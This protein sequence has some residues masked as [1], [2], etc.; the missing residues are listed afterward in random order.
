MKITTNWQICE[1][2]LT[3]VQGR[4]DLKQC[5]LQMKKAKITH[6]VQKHMYFIYKSPG[7]LLARVR[8]ILLQVPIPFWK[9]SLIFLIKEP[10]GL[11]IL[12]TS[13]PNAVADIASR[14]KPPYNLYKIHGSLHGSLWIA[15]F[16]SL[17]YIF[18]KWP[19]A[20][21]HVGFHIENAML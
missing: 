15:S 6:A 19:T 1:D 12:S 17:R 16:I 9:I 10:S 20:D 13:N 5:C 14:V 2:L 7:C 8:Q 21:L 3:P 11:L 4:G 18:I